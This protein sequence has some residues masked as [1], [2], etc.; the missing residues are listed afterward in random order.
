MGGPR[1]FSFS[2]FLSGDQIFA[3][4]PYVELGGFRVSAHTG[5]SASDEDGAGAD[6]ERTHLCS[7][8]VW[9]LEVPLYFFSGS[10]K[11]PS[12]SNLLRASSSAHVCI[13]FDI[14]SI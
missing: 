1:P 3:F 10:S 12:A 13:L 6:V 4:L 5:S 2:Y 7:D 14:V 11:M 8:L 9:A